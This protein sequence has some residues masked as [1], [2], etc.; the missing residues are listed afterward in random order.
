MIFREAL[1]DGT[2]EGYF[3]LA[4]QHHTQADPV[5]GRSR[6]WIELSRATLPRNLAFLF[7][8]IAGGGSRLLRFMES[9]LCDI[10][11]REQPTSVPLAMHLALEGAGEIVG[12][13]ELRAATDERHG[14]AVQTILTEL[15]ETPLFSLAREVGAPV[16]E[17]GAVLLYLVP[18]ETWK[19][20]SRD[21]AAEIARLSA[22]E[23]LPDPLRDEFTVLR[24]QFAE[25][26]AA[27]RIDGCAVRTP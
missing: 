7:T 2:M 14:S 4:E 25:L 23:R 5:T 10:L 15:R 20:L 24:S 27:R 12:S 26:R 3:P 1:A 18:R 17:L 6:G 16:P 22:I 11:R 21:I 19:V 9:D 13:I 8:R